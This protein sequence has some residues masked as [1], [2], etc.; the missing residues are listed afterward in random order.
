MAISIR[1]AGLLF[2]ASMATDVLAAPPN[3][4]R[5]SPPPGIE[6]RAIAPGAIAPE[7]SLD[8]TS[9]APWSLPRSLESGPV[10]LVFYRG[11]W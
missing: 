6:Q 2:L 11:D 4:T 1:S 3:A 7:V 10:V 5:E 8:S 9:G